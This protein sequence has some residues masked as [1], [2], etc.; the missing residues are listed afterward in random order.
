MERQ[1]IDISSREHNGRIA[2][3]IE[4]EYGAYA[5]ENDAISL[6]ITLPDRYVSDDYIYQIYFHT[7]DGKDYNTE[8]T[9]YPISYDL[10]SSLM[11]NGWLDLQ[12]IILAGKE[13]IKKTDI[14]SLWIKRSLSNS[15][16]AIDEHGLE[17]VDAA[18]ARLEQIVQE[19]NELTVATIPEIEALF[20]I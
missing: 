5:G 11:V 3:Q 4:T 16:T 15:E 19:I 7:A 20:E 2:L 18:A 6:N 10:P 8:T 9:G 1:R 13:I 14:C 17:S 12:V